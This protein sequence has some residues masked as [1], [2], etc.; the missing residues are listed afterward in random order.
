MAVPAKPM[1]DAECELKSSG[2]VH[3]TDSVTC[4]PFLADRQPAM[5]G[6]AFVSR[7]FSILSATED[8]VL[9]SRIEG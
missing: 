6:F 9:S 8:V 4:G 3:A 5:G 2:C 7:Q 1:L